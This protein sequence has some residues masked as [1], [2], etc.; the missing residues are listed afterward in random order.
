MLNV[1]TLKYMKHYKQY[2]GIKS[3]INPETRN[4]TYLYCQFASFKIYLKFLFSTNW[5]H[6]L[7]SNVFVI[8]FYSKAWLKLYLEI[9]STFSKDTKI[10]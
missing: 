1:E 3:S 4:D 5:T 8:K 7:L 6:N 9:F 2:Y 10:K